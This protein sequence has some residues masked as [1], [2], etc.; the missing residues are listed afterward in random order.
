MI[1]DCISLNNEKKYNGNQFKDFT[2]SCMKCQ[3][4]EPLLLQSVHQLAFQ[5]IVFS[6]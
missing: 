6:K 3:I 2:F 5:S 1:I 4:Y